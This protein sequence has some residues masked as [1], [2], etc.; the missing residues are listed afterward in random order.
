MSGAS[1]P[2]TADAMEAESATSMT[3]A[4]ASQFGGADLENIFRPGGQDNVGARSLHVAGDG[5]S[6]TTAG[7]RHQRSLSFERECLHRHIIAAALRG[8]AGRSEGAAAPGKTGRPAEA[9]VP[10]ARRARRRR[11]AVFGSC[12]SPGSYARGRR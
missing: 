3:R 12:S 4:T 9:G 7:P 11:W 8:A 2:F 6:D 10:K 5:E 1:R